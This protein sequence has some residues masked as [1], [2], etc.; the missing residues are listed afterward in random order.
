M[1]KKQ[2]R[3]RAVGAPPKS[4]RSAAIARGR[5]LG[6][7]GADD[8]AR[9][10][11]LVL[12]PRMLPRIRA[13]ARC[14]SLAMTIM[15]LYAVSLLGCVIAAALYIAHQR[16]AHAHEQAIIAARRRDEIEHREREDAALADAE[17]LDAMIARA[18]AAETHR[19]AQ[20]NGC[21]SRRDESASRT[22]GR[23]SPRSLSR[24]AGTPTAAVTPEGVEA[25]G[26]ARQLDTGFPVGLP[27]LDP[28]H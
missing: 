27:L 18:Q 23:P 15:W 2:A 10:V 8:P 16:R 13:Q 21:R 9:R 7:R 1:A 20:Q 11:P 26:E 4:P 3:A 12:G 5:F 25:M 28:M 19:Q 17:P 14:R 22:T 24:S 6:A